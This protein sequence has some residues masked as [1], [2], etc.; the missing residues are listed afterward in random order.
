M[1]DC[2]EGSSSSRPS[3]SIQ[4]RF[5]QLTRFSLGRT[6]NKSSTD[7]SDLNIAPSGTELDN[8][9]ASAQ[10]TNTVQTSETADAIAKSW[11]DVVVKI[12]QKSLGPHIPP[13]GYEVSCCRRVPY[14]RNC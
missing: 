14:E 6:T 1:S 4:S 3:G 9:A 10:H 12:I 7:Q 11:K 13:S 5:S 2:P 8:P